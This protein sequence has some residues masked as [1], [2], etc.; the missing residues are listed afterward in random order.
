MRSKSASYSLNK[1]VR[2]AF[3]SMAPTLSSWVVNIA[4]V[5][6]DKNIADLASR[7]ERFL[8]NA[9]AAK[10]ARRA[11]LEE[12]HVSDVPSA[13]KRLVGGRLAASPAVLAVPVIRPT[14]M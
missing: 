9:V 8:S 4:H 2:E 11:L 14:T 3:D 7:G 10:R 1:E 12:H 6:T 5:T 13:L